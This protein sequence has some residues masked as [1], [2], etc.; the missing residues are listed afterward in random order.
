MQIR[1]LA[2]SLAG[3]LKANDAVSSLCAVCKGIQA[4][5][6]LCKEHN[7]KNDACTYYLNR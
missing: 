7:Q 2:K 1:E 6:W 5:G 3:D 4:S